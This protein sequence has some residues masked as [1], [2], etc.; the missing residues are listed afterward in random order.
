MQSDNAFLLPWETT[1]SAEGKLHWQGSVLW[2]IT[3][4][5][6]QRTGK[7]ASLMLPCWHCHHSSQEGTLNKSLLSAGV[8]F[9]GRR[10]EE[11]CIVPKEVYSYWRCACVLGQII[12]QADDGN[13]YLNKNQARIQI[14]RFRVIWSCRLF[15][16]SYKNPIAIPLKTWQ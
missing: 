14:W 13:S 12:C 8:P 2:W 6:Q 10:L 7:D 16:G 9:G 11:Q 3:R 15:R 5:A 1:P 4:C